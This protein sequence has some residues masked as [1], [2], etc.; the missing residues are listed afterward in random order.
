MKIFS[1]A[2]VCLI[3]V[4][5]SSNTYRASNKPKVAVVEPSLPSGHEKPEEAPE[6]PQELRT[7]K[8][9][10]RDS[11]NT[12]KKLPRIRHLELFNKYVING[13]GR[14]GGVHLD[15]SYTELL[16]DITVTGFVGGN[17]IYLDGRHSDLFDTTSLSGSCGNLGRAL[18]E[19]KFSNL[20]G[21]AEMSGSVGGSYVDIAV[22]GVN[23][24]THWA[25][26]TTVLLAEL[27]DAN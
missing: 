27:F 10:S 12:I 3:I 23:D 9:A 15:V 1:V 21:K 11:E 7:E 13:K 24:R 14:Y 19:V 16:E 17:S 18:L 6:L 8:G 26:S 2:A 4:G 25:Y 20:Y 22:S 5:C